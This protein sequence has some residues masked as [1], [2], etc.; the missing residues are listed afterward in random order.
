LPNQSASFIERAAALGRPQLVAGFEEPRGRHHVR[1]SKEVGLR[2]NELAAKP[3]PGQKWIKRVIA[4]MGG[5]DASIVAADADLDAA[6]DGVCASAFGFSGQKCSACSR[7]IVEAP[8]YEAFLDKLLERVRKLSVGDPS[9]AAACMGPVVNDR[10]L[11][12]ILRYIEE[13][14]KGARA[15]FFVGNLYLWR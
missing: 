4:E 11:R 2:V 7:A 6:A 8:V 12:G 5:K 3:Q 10:A 15:E 14:K 9:D 1:D 13:G